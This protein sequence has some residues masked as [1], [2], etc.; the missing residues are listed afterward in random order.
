MNLIQMISPNQ[1]PAHIKAR[2]ELAVNRERIL[3]TILVVIMLASAVGYIGL[4]VY[5]LPK[6]Q[7]GLFILYT[8]LTLLIFVYTAYR[9]MAYTARTL[10]ITLSILGTTIFTFATTGLGGNGEIYLLAFIAL[11]TVLLGWKAGLI[12]LI[13]THLVFIVLGFLILQNLIILPAGLDALAKNGL[14]DW[15]R[16]GVILNDRLNYGYFFDWDVN[17]RS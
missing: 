6:Q 14:T 15:V 8:A 2:G 1:P 12:S 9:K 16:T 4:A 17:S 11:T 3:Q 10:I 5:S 13:S 7:Y